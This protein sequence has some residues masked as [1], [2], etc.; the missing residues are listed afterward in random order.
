MSFKEKLMLSQLETIC[1][2]KNIVS[3]SYKFIN[4]VLYAIG[5]DQSSGGKYATKRY[6]KI[7]LFGALSSLTYHS[8]NVIDSTAN[9]TLE[10]LR[11]EVKNHLNYIT[12]LI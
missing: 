12:E 8:S 1:K 4:G 10:E 5:Y 3:K 7:V 11:K 2:E 6:H 9:Y